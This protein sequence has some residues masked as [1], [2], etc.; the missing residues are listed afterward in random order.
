ML[1]LLLLLPLSVGEEEPG[2]QAC[3][4]IFMSW[5]G[6]G[7]VNEIFSG[8]LLFTLNHLCVLIDYNACIV[9]L[10]KTK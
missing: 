6:K 2:S 4:F 1:K 10:K 5:A 9:K 7:V 3:F 8:A